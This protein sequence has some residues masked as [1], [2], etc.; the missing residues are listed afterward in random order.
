MRACAPPTLELDTMGEQPKW[1]NELREARVRKAEIDFT[2]EP[3]LL[4]Y[5]DLYAT[6]RNIIIVIVLMY[7]LFLSFLVLYHW[8]ETKVFARRLLQRAIRTST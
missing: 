3:S 5:L 7:S 4:D 8:N 1:V 6:K 2:P